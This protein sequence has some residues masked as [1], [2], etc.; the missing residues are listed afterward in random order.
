MCCHMVENSP[1]PAHSLSAL[2]TVV[3]KEVGRS[4]YTI[5]QTAIESRVD[6]CLLFDNR[7][8]EEQVQIFKNSL[9][10]LIH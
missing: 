2:M 3:L 7:I 5:L 9:L 8:H 1:S 6:D 10:L 4:R